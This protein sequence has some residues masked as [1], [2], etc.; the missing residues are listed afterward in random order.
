MKMCS[1]ATH[2]QLASLSLLPF[3]SG[4]VPMVVTCA[5]HPIRQHQ[6][7]ERVKAKQAVCGGGLLGI[8]GKTDCGM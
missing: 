1:P 8:R 4:I 3:S 6:T 7:R 5:C 2:T